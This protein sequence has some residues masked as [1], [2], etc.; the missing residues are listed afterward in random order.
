MAPASPIR[1]LMPFANAATFQRNLGS[2]TD[3]ALVRAT[4]TRDIHVRDRGHAGVQCQDLET[5][6]WW[7]AP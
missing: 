2:Y 4:C 5:R 6:P 7:T 1:K 3:A